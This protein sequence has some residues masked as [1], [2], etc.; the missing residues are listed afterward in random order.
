MTKL[1]R[2]ALIE[3]HRALIANAKRKTARIARMTLTPSTNVTAHQSL[4]RQ[5]VCLLDA[6]AYVR[7]EL[8]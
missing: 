4:R 1:S 8:G 7:R 2:P 5:V 3:V 6:A